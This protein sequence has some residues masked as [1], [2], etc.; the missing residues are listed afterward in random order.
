MPDS[1]TARRRPA[2][3]P[4]QRDVGLHAGEAAAAAGRRA[5]ATPLVNRLL[6]GV[7]GE[8]RGLPVRGNQAEDRW[9]EHDAGDELSDDGRLADPQHRFPEQPPDEQQGRT[10]CATKTASDG[11]L[12]PPSAARACTAH[13]LAAAPALPASHQRAVRVIP[14]LGIVSSP[15]QIRRVA[16]TSTAAGP[17]SD[18][19]VAACPPMAAVRRKPRDRCRGGLRRSAQR[20]PGAI[21]PSRWPPPCAVPSCPPAC[22]PASCPPACSPR[23]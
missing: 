8:D 12:P 11:P 10:T 23:S 15:P 20:L 2:D 13:R 19:R 22:S 5:W 18:G 9:P 16:D 21:V 14:S 17:R 3:P 6:R 7:G 1:E 4:H